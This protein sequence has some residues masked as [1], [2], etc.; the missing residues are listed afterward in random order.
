MERGRTNNEAV[1]AAI[2]PTPAPLALPDDPYAGRLSFV[3]LS[4][5]TH[6]DVWPRSGVENHSLED[7]VENRRRARREKHQ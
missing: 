4:H 1:E 3:I 2:F 6:I 7:G 5:R